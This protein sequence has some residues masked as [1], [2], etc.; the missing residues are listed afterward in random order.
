MLVYV[1]KE[2]HSKQDDEHVEQR[3]VL[4]SSLVYSSSEFVVSNSV[5]AYLLYML[6]CTRRD[7]VTVCT[8]RGLV[9]SVREHH[10][11]RKGRNI[12]SL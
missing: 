3:E 7:C 5:Y 10:C 4:Y 12:T 11:S 1:I 9:M 8:V 6:W 2:Q